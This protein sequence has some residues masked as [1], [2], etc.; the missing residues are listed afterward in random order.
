[1]RTLP[2][3][4]VSV[5]SCGEA[6]ARSGGKL[7][8][9][10]CRRISAQLVAATNLTLD[11]PGIGNDTAI[12]RLD[13]AQA[14]PRFV[15]LNNLAVFLQLAT[16]VPPQYR[17]FGQLA[18]AGASMPTSITQPNRPTDLLPMYGAVPLN[19]GAAAGLLV[20]VTAMPSQGQTNTGYYYAPSDLATAN[21]ALGVKVRGLG[22][23][24][25]CGPGERCLPPFC[26]R[27]GR[28]VHRRLWVH[29]PV[30]GHLLT[31]QPSAHLVQVPPVRDNA[32]PPIV[33]KNDPKICFLP[34]AP[35]GCGEA[36]LDIQM[37][38]QVRIS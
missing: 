15:G 2:A 16:S 31:E 11:G 14:L 35:G 5:M 18:S 27:A 1:V 34:N 24:V 36:A 38:T 26:S 20:T 32:K 9:D 10:T 13:L 7:A 3:S 22:C 23:G 17:R 29:P 8:H 33:P 37:T 21:T 4:A 12:Y 28:V 19:N 30:A 6:V 25:G